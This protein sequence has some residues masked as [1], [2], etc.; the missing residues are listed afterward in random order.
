MSLV[1]IFRNKYARSWP[2]LE[3]DKPL[4]SVD[5]GRVVELGHALD[6]DYAGDAHFAPYRSPNGQRLNYQ[7]LAQGTPIELH[8]IVFDVDGPGHAATPA[9]RRELREKV[10]SLAAAHP[11]PFYYETRGGGR[12]V[13]GQAEPTILET[14]ADALEWSRVYTIAVAHLEQ[15]FGIVADPACCDW[16]RLYRLPRATRDRGGSPENHPYWGNVDKIG[17]LTIQ[18]SW[19]D[20]AKATKTNERVFRQPRTLPNFAGSGDGLL[21]WLLKLRGEIIGTE[22][23]GGWICRCPNRNQHTSCTDGTSST[24]CYPPRAIG[25]LGVIVCKHGHC[26]GHTLRQWLA[27][28]SDSEIEAAREAAGIVRTR[29]A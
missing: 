17:N 14:E 11:D 23:R 16:Q 28:F 1:T 25:E 21:F 20:V 2:Q 29:V 15:R 10:V 6:Q 3:A 26:V 18:A 5:R 22:S 12:V 24:I 19:A 9:W 7:A 4:R 27:Y 13:Y 8:A